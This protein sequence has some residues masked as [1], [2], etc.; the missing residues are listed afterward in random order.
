MAIDN[1]LA[2][3]FN[4]RLGSL[5]VVIH[6]QTVSL[7]HNSSVELDTQD[8]SSWAQNPAKFTSA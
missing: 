2:K 8:A 1:S 4:P 7:Y 5:Y 6:R 3:E